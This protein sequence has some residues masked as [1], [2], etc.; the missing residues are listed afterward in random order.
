MLA[1]LVQGSRLMT[2]QSA[3]TDRQKSNVAGTPRPRTGHALRR[4]VCVALSHHADA[5]A[6]C[7]EQHV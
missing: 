2:S 7:E 6:N 1:A 5:Q 3:G 4:A